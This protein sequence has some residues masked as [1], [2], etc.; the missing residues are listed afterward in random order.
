MALYSLKI[1]IFKKIFLRE[2][3]IKY[4]KTDIL[5]AD[6]LIKNNYLELQVGPAEFRK[7]QC[8]TDLTGRYV[9][10]QAVSTAIHFTACEMKVLQKDTA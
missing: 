3:N 8:T 4:I 10:I 1:L 5:N 2:N 6:I 9:I 7:L